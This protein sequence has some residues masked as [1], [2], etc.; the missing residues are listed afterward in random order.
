M[1]DSIVATLL[2]LKLSKENALLLAA[3][4]VALADDG[5]SFAKL[6]KEIGG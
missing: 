3:W 6:L 1:G 4:I 5:E 2:G